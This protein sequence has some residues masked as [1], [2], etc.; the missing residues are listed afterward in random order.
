ME[1]GKRTYTKLT[2]FAGEDR[3]PVWGADGTSFYYLSEKDGTFNVYKRKVDG[4][5]E[6]Q[7]T[8]HTQHPVRFL[9]AARN[10]MLCYGY[11]GEIYTLKEGEQP[12]KVAIRIVTDQTEQALEPQDFGS[13]GNSGIARRERNRFH[14]SRGCV[15]HLRRL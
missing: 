13:Y 5:D 15:C 8:L 9:T 2:D 14:P 7:L 10:G 4:T 1:S 6:K 12:R 3:T 11:N